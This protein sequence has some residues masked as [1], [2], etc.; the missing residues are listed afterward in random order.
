GDLDRA[1]P[2]LEETL[3]LEKARLGPDHPKTLVA[4]SNLALS[5][6]NAGR[7]HASIPLML[8]CLKRQ[9]KKLG[10]DHYVT[11]V[12]VNNLGAFYRDAGQLDE[13]LPLLEESYQTGQRLPRFRQSFGRALLDGYVQAGRSAEATAL[14][15]ELLIG[16]RK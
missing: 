14:A 4:M 5:Y 8:E 6:R 9:E 15:E 10:R 16:A 13:A 11:L 12:M 7:L 1:L 2:L 3:R